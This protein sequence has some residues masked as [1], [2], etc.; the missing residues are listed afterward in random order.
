[1]YE[2]GAQLGIAGSENVTKHGEAG[3]VGGEPAVLRHHSVA[4]GVHSVKHWLLR[5][6]K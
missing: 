4:T 6:H 2:V 3:R 1:M 5:A